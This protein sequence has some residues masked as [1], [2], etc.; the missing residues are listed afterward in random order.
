VERRTV[1]VDER[2]VRGRLAHRGCAA[3]NAHANDSSPLIMPPSARA[4]RLGRIRLTYETQPTR[5]SLHRAH[6][7]PGRAGLRSVD[8]CDGA[9][10]LLPSEQPPDRLHV[11]VEL[12]ADAESDAPRQGKPR[13]ACRLRDP[14]SGN[15]S[16]VEPD[17]SWSPVGR[18]TLGEPARSRQAIHEPTRPTTYR[19]LRTSTRRDRHVTDKSAVQSRLTWKRQDAGPRVSTRGAGR[20]GVRP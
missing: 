18:Q 1:L 3:V 5:I 20:Y 16:S 7:K 17:R 10:L 11:T 9:P 4:P 15:Q 6:G 13:S 12:Q 8:R 14:T 19:T 2:E